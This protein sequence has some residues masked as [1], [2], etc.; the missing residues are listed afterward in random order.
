MHPL[1]SAAGRD[2]AMLV[3]AM[4]AALRNPAQPTQCLQPLAPETARRDAAACMF[5]PDQNGRV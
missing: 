4:G 1:H 3:P 5:R 2:G